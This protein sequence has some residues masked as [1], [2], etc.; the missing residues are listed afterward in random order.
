MAATGADDH[1][2]PGTESRVCIRTVDC[3][4]IRAATPGEGSNQGEGAASWWR[5]ARLSS[6]PRG[7]RGWYC[8]QVLRPGAA[9]RYLR[10]C[11]QFL[12]GGEK[13]YLRRGCLPLRWPTTPEGS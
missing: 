2:R 1:G 7:V 11:A 4:P 9:P 3:H 8:A 6:G 10:A 13:G 12:R 5:G